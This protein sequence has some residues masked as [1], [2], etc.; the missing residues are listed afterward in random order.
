[1][2]QKN[3]LQKI[4]DRKNQDLVNML[5][6]LKLNKCLNEIYNKDD[7]LVKSEKT[8]MIKTKIINLFLRLFGD[9]SIV[10]I[11]DSGNKQANEI[12]ISG[13]ETIFDELED[14]IKKFKITENNEYSNSKHNQ[15]D[16]NIF[17]KKI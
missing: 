8:R 11:C 5:F 15:F 1:M 17:E 12:T 10:E 6:L 13:N 7:L 4:E 2:C 16:K 3:I 14:E 9:S